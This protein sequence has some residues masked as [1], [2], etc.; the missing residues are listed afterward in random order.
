MHNRVMTTRS[1]KQM[2]ADTLVTVSIGPTVVLGRVE[3][4]DGRKGAVRLDDGRLKRIYKDRLDVW[5]VWSLRGTVVAP[6]V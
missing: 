6:R 5:R 3:K 2:T 4:I 1:T